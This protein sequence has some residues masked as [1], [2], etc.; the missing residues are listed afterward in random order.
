MRKSAIVLGT[1]DGLHKG[2]EAVLSLADEFQSKTVITFPFP[3]AM[4][5][6][7]ELLISE[8]EKNRRL[9]ARGFELCVLDFGKVCGMEAESFLEWIYEK[10]SPAAICCGFNYRFG[11]GGRGNTELIKRFCETKGIGALIAE[12]ERENDIKI[13]SSLIRELIKR[14]EVAH[15]N[16]LLGRPFSVCG[17]VLHGDSRGRTMG[18]PTVNFPYPE[19]IVMARHGVYAARAVVNGERFKAVSYIGNRPTYQLDEVICETNL[20]DFAGDLYGK[21]VTVELCEFLRDDRKFSSKEE[22]KAQIEKDIEKT[23]LLI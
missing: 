9:S 5:E 21:T 22:L 23:K 14:G 19:D 8:K 12:A 18:I 16:S 13:S 17:S 11:H 20:L 3:P 7:R 6:K 4:D 1:F 10:Y 2:H 15:A